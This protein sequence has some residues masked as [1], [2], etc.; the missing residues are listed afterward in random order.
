M[1]LSIPFK[2]RVF[3][4]MTIPI[5]MAPIDASVVYVA[6]P[7]IS[8]VFGA[9]P[10][11]VGWIS[12]SYLLV[13][14]SFLLSLGRLGDMFGFRKIFLGGIAL[15]TA[16]SVLC[17]TA[18]SISTLI[19]FRAIQAV[20]A[21]MTMA[22]SPAIITATFPS[23]ERGRALGTM[24][25][26]VAL[27]LAIGPSLGGLL[28]EILGWRSIFFINLP[29]GIVAYTACHY[30]LIEKE[31]LKKQEFDWPGAFLALVSLTSLLFFLSRGQDYGWSP[32]II[33]FG[34]TAIITGALFIR[35][36][37]KASQPMLDLGLFRSQ[38]FTAGNTAALFHFMTQYII[39]FITPFYLQEQLGFTA[40]KVGITMTAF[41]L[42]V[43]VAAPLSGAL[44]DKIGNRLLSSAGAV[45]CMLGALFL[46][47]AGDNVS[48]IDIAW[49]LSI[50][51]LGTGMFQAP[52]NSAIMGSVSLK[53]LGIAGGVLS[54]T[55]NVGM[56]LGIAAG[57]AVLVIR[58]D[59]YEQAGNSLSRLTAMH[60][61]YITAAA[62]SLLC[63]TACLFAKA[64]S[65]Q[66]KKAGSA[67]AGMDE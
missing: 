50:F 47:T 48:S 20:G 67:P 23:E 36:E 66:Q 53:R 58:Q 31:Q 9:G 59:F 8:K 15:F 19:I 3:L 61:A 29:L 41:P 25:M 43:F 39:I 57:S 4:A 22:L 30:M 34:I 17:G 52:N 40:S 42:T 13:L 10:G 7:S 44:S 54:T 14:S 27:G 2:W 26:I 45:F 6:F 51:G 60:D 62:L 46:S 18:W 38:A 37:Q 24:G 11:L 63:F 21:G 12:M 35:H 33:A 28:L 56:V 5:L 1:T 55:R 49:R 32:F 64:G 16:S 65:K